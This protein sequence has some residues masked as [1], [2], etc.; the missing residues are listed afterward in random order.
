M[1]TLLRS[2]LL[3]TLIFAP[4]FCAT[5]EYKSVSVGDSVYKAEYRQDGSLER[6]VKLNKRGK[7]LAEAFYG[8]DGKLAKNPVDNWAAAVWEYGDGKLIEQC[9]YG[10]DGRLKERKS[11]TPA[12]NLREKDY[13]GGEIDENEEL[14]TEFMAADEVSKYF[15]ASGSRLEGETESLR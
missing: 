3:F 12:G 7:K 4:A 11:Y 15:D 6:V 10:T 9:Y 2:I 13:L 1:Y 5:E 8:P 14:D